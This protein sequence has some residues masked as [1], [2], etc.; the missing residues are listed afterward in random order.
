MNVLYLTHRV[1]YPPDKGDK[2]R[3]FH[4][5]RFLAERHRVWCACFVDDP[6]DKMHFETLRRYCADLA[7][8]P[9]NRALALRNG[10]LSV[11]SGGTVTEGHYRSTAMQAALGR[12]SKSVA[13]D[14]V[15]A[16]SSCMAPYALAVPAKR[17]VLD[18]CDVDSQKW[19]DY[20]ARTAAPMRRLYGVEGRR[21][22]EAECRWTEAFDAVT[23]VTE[24]E[25]Q[26]L[27]C[28]VRERRIATD[29]KIHVV[30]NGVEVPDSHSCGAP[31]DDSQVVGFV[32]AMNYR[33]NVDAV[34]WFAD[35]CWPHIHRQFPGAIFRIV[36][37]A[38]TKAVRRL[39]GRDRIEVTGAVPDAS[40]E[41]RK[42]AVSV[43]PLRLARGI[44]NKVL[45]AMAAAKP[46]VIT[47]VAAASLGGQDGVHYHIADGG[48]NFT[49]AVARFL[50]SDRLRR[51]VGLAARELVLERYQWSDALAQLEAALT[52]PVASN[53]APSE[54]LVERS[55]SVDSDKETS[56]HESLL[57]SATDR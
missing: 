46:V 44:Q 3:T 2:V 49:E 34:C 41:V 38:P 32:G 33:P 45:E 6:A 17:R 21:L 40:A 15:L 55:Q 11:L 7:F 19:L 37:R 12:W 14:A 50:N 28:A 9:L 54:N 39:A 8:V 13:F 30:S 51:Q 26:L 53:D 36:G 52:I 18:L 42:F 29:A 56:A 1:P 35:Q 20:A 47:P 31:S 23:L 57:T 5:L 25:A 48:Q 24:A 27:A 10:V 43:A 16:F 4:H 22:A